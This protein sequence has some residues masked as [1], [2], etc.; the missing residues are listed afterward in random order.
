MLLF[1]IPIKKLM[2][3][4]LNLNESD[5]LK[6]MPKR[7]VDDLKNNKDFVFLKS[8]EEID[9]SGVPL[10]VI[11][12]FKIW[13]ANNYDTRT[14][15]INPRPKPIRS[16]RVS[17]MPVL[18]DKMKLIFGDDFDWSQEKMRGFAKIAK[19]FNRPNDKEK[20][21]NEIRNENLEVPKWAIEI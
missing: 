17:Q 5:W 14:I 12:L 7:S 15:K 10:E 11:Q 20:L 18:R 21:Q 3:K 13:K 8:Y 6:A 1:D 2:M 9:V 16:Y 19:I 4:T